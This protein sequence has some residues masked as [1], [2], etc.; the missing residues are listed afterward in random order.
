MLPN[1]YKSLCEQT[2]YNF[3]WLVVDD[4]STDGTEKLIAAWKQECPFGITYI[5]TE[6]QGKASAINVGVQNANGKLFFIVDSDDFLTN[7]A[8]GDI[9][10]AEKELSSKK[11]AFPVA[12]L[13][14]RRRNYNTGV[15]IAAPVP[16]PDFA[17]SLELAFEYKQAGD[18]A[19]IFYTDVLRQFPFPV[20]PQNKFIPE[21][22]VWYR[23]AAAGYKFC[24]VDRAIYMCEYIEDGYTKNFSANL[25]RNWR[26]FRLFYK[27]AM[28]YKQIPLLTKIIYFIRVIQCNF[29][30]RG[31]S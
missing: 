29:Y 25:K 26:G 8:I 5:K 23:I 19:E 10:S 1:L 22:L 27:E 4:G 2:S 7:D 28:H 14:Y 6:N 17:D 24:T 3:E 21:A 16:L 11:A 15:V 18:K 9:D 20:I 31:K 30:G 13:C 12:G